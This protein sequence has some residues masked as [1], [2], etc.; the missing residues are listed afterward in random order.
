MEAVMK[1]MKKICAG[2]VLI[3]A[4]VG[5]KPL[6]DSLS[7]VQEEKLAA[8]TGI[9]SISGSTWYYDGISSSDVSKTKGSSLAVEFSRPVAVASSSDGKSR[10]SGSLEASYT[11][12]SGQSS[13]KKWTISGGE[14]Q[15]D[16]STSVSAGSLNASG[17]LFRLNMDSLLSL[18]DGKTVSN[19]EISVKITLSGFVAAEGSQK[20]RSVGT[21]VKNISVKPFYDASVVKGGGISFSTRGSTEGKFVVIPTLGKVR[22]SDDAEVTFESEESSVSGVKWTAGTCESG[23]TLLCDTDLQGKNFTGTFTVSGIVPELNASSY[24]RSFT[25][26]FSESISEDMISAL[27]KD[28]LPSDSSANAASGS[29][30]IYDISSLG[31]YNDETYL[32]A[33]LSFTSTPAFWNEELVTIL[34]D[35]V[36]DGTGNAANTKV[37]WVSGTE[38]KVGLGTA[39]SFAEGT[40]VEGQITTYVKEGTIFTTLDYQKDGEE[41]VS[42]KSIDCVNA[43][44]TAVSATYEKWLNTFS[45]AV[46]VY[47]IPL[48]DLGLEAGDKVRVY[49]AVSHQ[50]D[51]KW[52]AMSIADHVPAAAAKNSDGSEIAPAWVSGGESYVIDMSRALEHVIE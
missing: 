40:S 51:D 18:V 21:L 3:F 41:S 8:E 44:G 19:N 4:L 16:S 37:G 46:F 52:E 28:T 6:Q 47:K 32:Y 9:A 11:L 1:M 5:C 49:G 48:A 25:V 45:S 43:S 35:N 22:L 23:I 39:V 38:P 26:S 27:S 12:S 10:L 24:T 36:S 34:V 42:H 20:G 14:I 17:T 29:G 13:S 15:I 33:V 30:G 50:L 31:M 7:S 2:A